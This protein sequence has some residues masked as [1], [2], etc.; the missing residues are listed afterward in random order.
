MNDI[1]GFSETGE[2]LLTY[3]V[4]DEALEIAAGTVREKA[5]NYTLAACSGLSVCPA[6]PVYLIGPGF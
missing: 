4:S 2:E 3:K 1:I 6:W 5:V